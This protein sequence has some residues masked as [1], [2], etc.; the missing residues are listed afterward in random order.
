MARKSTKRMDR[1]AFEASCAIYHAC[2]ARGMSDAEA[3]KASDDY[4]KARNAKE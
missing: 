3:M 1:G 2:I 4:L